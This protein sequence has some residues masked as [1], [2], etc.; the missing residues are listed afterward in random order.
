MDQVGRALAKWHLLEEGYLV[1]FDLFCQTGGTEED[2]TFR[3]DLAGIRLRQGKAE[4]AVM[5]ALRNWWHPQAYLTPSLVRTHLL[6]GI[7]ETLSDEA[8]QAFR[9]SFDLGNAPVDKLLFF[10]HASPEKSSEAESILHGFG[11]ETI[12]LERIAARLLQTS[13]SRSLQSDPLLTQVV[14]LLKGTLRETTEKG[15]IPKAEKPAEPDLP[16]S[17]QLLLDFLG[18]SPPFPEGR[19]TGPGDEET[20]DGEKP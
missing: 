7:T 20:P 6:P 12:Y 5:G 14:S 11:I 19:S 17:P 13:G 2:Q 8:V 10:S 15:P 18:G 16:P 3:L 4:R 9:R 1:S